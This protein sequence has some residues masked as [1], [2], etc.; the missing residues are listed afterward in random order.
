[1]KKMHCIYKLARP[2]G[3][4]TALAA[5]LALQAG[6]AA[7]DTP[8]AF[9]IN[10]RP[11][12]VPAA[13]VRWTLGLGSAPVPGTTAV[14]IGTATATLGGGWVN[15]TTPNGD[16]R[17][18]IDSTGALNNG[19]T[20]LYEARSHFAGSNFCKLKPGVVPGTFPQSVALNFS[21]PVVTQHAIVTYTVS[22]ATEAETINCNQARRRVDSAPAG[23]AALP[24]GVAALSRHPLDVVLLLDKS[25]SMGWELPG[26]APGA[27]PKRWDVLKTALDQFEALWEQA[28]ES[29]VV[30]DRLG[31]V[32]F[33]SGATP[34][35]FGAGSI[36][37]KRG[38]N[39]PGPGHDWNAVLAAAKLPSP[40][41]GTAL[42]AGLN[43]AYEKIIADPASIDAVIVLVSDGEQNVDPKVVNIPSTTNLALRK[44]P[45]L[46]DPPT[47]NQDELFAKGIPVQTIALG[48]PGSSFSTVLDNIAKQTAGTSAVQTS[49][50][51][52]FT[53][54]Q[55]TLL[56]ALKGNTLGLLARASGSVSPPGTVPAAVLL[57]IDAS[58][59]RATAVL[60]WNGRPGLFEIFFAAP[61]GGPVV[62]P[63]I[64]KT[65][66]NWIVASV[67]LPTNGPPGAWTA[68]VR[69]RDIGQ[70][71]AFDLSVYATDA[72]LK[73]NLALAKGS[74]GTGDPLQLSAEISYDGVPLTGIAGGVRVRPARPSEG[75]GNLLHAANNE[76]APS[77]PD[78]NPYSAK[79]AALSRTS[80]LLS[81]IAAKPGSELL[82][83][84]AGSFGDA[85]ANDGIYSATVPD[86]R[87]PGRY[88]FD[89]VLEW[90]DPRTGK[91]RRIESIEREVR[92]V[93]SVAQSSLA[94]V[95]G[96]TPGN[97]LIR[98]TP[99][100][101]FRNFVG[102]GYDDRISVRLNGA[103]T[104]AAATDARLQ[105]DYEVAV[106]NATATRYTLTL[107]DV[108]LAQDAPLVAG[109]SG[110]G[111]P[112]H[113]AVWFA[114]GRTVPHGSFSNFNGGGLSATL[115]FE[116]A[117]SS[118][119]SA[120]ITLSGHR[121]DGKSG[122]S[123]IDVTQFGI[124]GKWYFSAAPLR[125]FATAGVA[126][127]A[128]D[129]GRTRGG[130]NAGLGLQYNF[131][132]TLALDARYG[133]HHVL[134][135]A[136]ATDFSTLQV[137][138]RFAF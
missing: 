52:L 20:V 63:A 21:G 121:F 107:D 90:D 77:D 51:G 131:T 41:G 113:Y 105:G 81:R 53:A 110:G 128:F 4:A 122:G 7:A 135:N 102:P 54:M 6:P 133:L 16:D 134:S 25:G 74:D 120:E 17:F 68:F 71:A 126:S 114:L 112:S 66:S 91:V 99:Q 15:A 22:G 130:L 86:T 59:R 95:A 5:T 14:S 125:W 137:G 100:D 45:P 119:H 76:S 30:G 118:T 58:A 18:R 32:H 29:D 2:S 111:G 104:V 39:L 67:D 60:S 72:R 80:D 35:D 38:S 1:M 27:P 123:N 33:D 11:A 69:A 136:P 37:K 129:P 23:I 98:V 62:Q 48:T 97:F 85:T 12:K 36:F 26:N 31:L 89:V 93:P 92:A 117:F 19:V 9:T 106:T 3:L 84:D 87:V 115:G 103:G 96:S 34:A 94:V 49:A 73:Y 44:T 75:I 83:A 88:R 101:R 10:D 55:D 43:L 13:R 46:T 82:L 42:G 79:V 47:P 108:V 57:Q 70:P 8:L 40:S 65:G 64:S 127:Y 24:N 132:P 124:N 109:S 138:L 50:T 28:A 61:G 78:Q 116:Y 56:R